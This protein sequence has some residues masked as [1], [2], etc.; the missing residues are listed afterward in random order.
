MSGIFPFSAILDFLRDILMQAWLCLAVVLRPIV[1]DTI[2]DA[3]PFIMGG[4][5]VTVGSVALALGM[6]LVL[7]VPMAV[8]Q[9]YGN[10]LARRLVGLY[11]WF[12]R[13][14]PILVLLFLSQ[15]LFLSMGWILEPFLLSCLVMGC[16]STAYQSQIFRGAIESLPQGQL[17]AARALGMRDLT[18][19]TCIILPQA[20][21]LSIPGWANEFS[22]LLKDSAVCYLLGTMEI[23]ARVNAVAQRTHEHLAFFALAGVIYFVLTLIVLKLLRRLEN[24][25]QIPG[26]SAGTVGSMAKN[27]QHGVKNA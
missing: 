7:G 18:A 2:V 4:T 25:V 1:G 6:G 9:V 10:A 19:I 23:M 11:V 14:V 24:K 15:G 22:I 27:T 21:R 5:L 20:L 16:I 8:L 3:F 13:G 17:K 26:Y 12:F